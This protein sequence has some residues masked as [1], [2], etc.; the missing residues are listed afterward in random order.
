M[1]F[2]TA[3]PPAELAVPFLRVNSRPPK[4]RHSQIVQ[5]ERLRRGIWGTKQLWGR[6]VTYP[7][8]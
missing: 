2:L 4:P 1:T 5:L 3:S 7:G 8:E 6:V